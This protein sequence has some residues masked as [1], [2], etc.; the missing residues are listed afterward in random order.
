MLEIVVFDPDK[1]VSKFKPMDDGGVVQH[2][3]EGGEPTETLKMSVFD[4]EY[5]EYIKNLEGATSDLFN[6]NVMRD[7]LDSFSVSSKS[8]EE[9]NP[10]E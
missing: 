2:M 7:V 10:K 1:I 6:D 4:E 5:D 3:S 8:L 9:V